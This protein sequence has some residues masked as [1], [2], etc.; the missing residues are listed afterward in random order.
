M[1]GC[2][3]FNRVINSTE[4]GEAADWLSELAAGTVSVAVAD[5][6]GTAPNW[7]DGTAVTIARPNIPWLGEGGVATWVPARDAGNIIRQAMAADLPFIA[8]GQTVQ[9][10]AYWAL[11]AWTGGPWTWQVGASTTTQLHAPVI[12][13]RRTD[14][15]A[16]VATG[17]MD[18]LETSAETWVRVELRTTYVVPS[19]APPLRMEILIPGGVTTSGGTQRMQVLPIFLGGSLDYGDDDLGVIE[20][21]EASDIWQEA[22]ERLR[23]SRAWSSTYVASRVDIAAAF[24]LDPASP[25][26]ELGGE[27]R[28]RSPS[29][30]VD[31]YLRVQEIQVSD[32]LAPSGAR[33]ETL[34]LEMDPARIT[35]EAVQRAGP[36]L[37]ARTGGVNAIASETPPQTAG[38]IGAS[39]PAGQPAPTILEPLTVG[40]L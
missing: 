23:V 38:A 40:V 18:A 13:L 7:S 34:V 39:V 31:E 11:G 15:N 1:L 17:N 8:E 22:Q 21:S 32:F 29:I 26:L 12:Q 16:V 6:V 19:P 2:A 37:Y 4:I 24:D 36:P 33:E 27:I 30:G 35:T 5:P 28:L 9:A 10:R 25:A 3:I 14:T 20:G